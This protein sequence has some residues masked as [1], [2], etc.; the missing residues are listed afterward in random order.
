M[1]PGRTFSVTSRKRSSSEV[2]IIRA[3]RVESTVAELRAR[4]MTAGE[5]RPRVCVVGGGPIGLEAATLLVAKG[6]GVEL[7]EQ[8]PCV[9]AAVHSWG[10]VQL[11]SNNT[12]NCSKYGGPRLSL[13]P[14]PVAHILPRPR[15]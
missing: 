13:E 15:A 6:F 11:F 10:H 12:L 2:E 7:I 4:T 8:G 5:G 3:S 1:V 9:A 14:I